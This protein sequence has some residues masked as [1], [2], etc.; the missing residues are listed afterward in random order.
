MP[1]ADELWAKI[2]AESELRPS[3]GIVSD[4]PETQ[5]IAEAEEPTE[6]PI[7][8]DEVPLPDDE[9][10]PSAYLDE[11]PIQ[12]VPF[13]PGTPPEAGD[14]VIAAA[15]F[16][17]RPVAEPVVDEVPPAM[18]TEV[19][20]PHPDPVEIVADLPVH[21]GDPAKTPWWKLMLGG[22]EPRAA[23]QPTAAPLPE[24]GAAQPK[25]PVM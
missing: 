20:T 11:A 25:R 9:P 23:K 22:G 1:V 24:P 17:V 10:E 18:I 16:E 4:V 15:P 6:D 14:E 19:P 5:V 13:H 12:I 7:E 2:S 3:R 8:L 21:E